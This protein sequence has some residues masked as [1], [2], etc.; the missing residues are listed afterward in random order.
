MTAINHNELELEIA[1]CIEITVSIIY[2]E[3]I[4]VAAPEEFEHERITRRR[5][6]ALETQ[7]I[8]TLFVVCTFLKVRSVRSLSKR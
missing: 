5:Q 1:A 6:C 4:T 2:R 8:Q 7:N 3:F